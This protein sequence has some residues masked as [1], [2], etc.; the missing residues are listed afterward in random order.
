MEM[1]GGFDAWKEH[2]MEIESGVSISK[3]AWVPG[4]QK[5]AA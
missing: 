2:D 5:A 1:D 4:A 3:G